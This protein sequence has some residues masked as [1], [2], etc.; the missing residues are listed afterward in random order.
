MERNWRNSLSFP[1]FVSPSPYLCFYLSPLCLSPSL[2]HSLSPSSSSSISFPLSPSVSL[3]PIFHSTSICPSIYLSLYLSLS[4]SI[5]CIPPS[6][7]YSLID[8]RKTPPPG[9][10]WLRLLDGLEAACL[11]DLLRG[12]GWGG[13]HGGGRLERL[14]GLTL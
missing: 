12:G 5:C 10:S 7:A 2:S 6:S 4:V 3:Q 9:E 11:V 13:G 14:A 8:I 1:L